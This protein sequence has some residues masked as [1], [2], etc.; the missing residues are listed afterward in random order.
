MDAIVGQFFLEKG[1]YGYSF[2]ISPVEKIM[3]SVNDKC[4]TGA[5]Q[6]EFKELIQGIFFTLFHS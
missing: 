1:G 5:K 3:G 6:K 4:L 2:F